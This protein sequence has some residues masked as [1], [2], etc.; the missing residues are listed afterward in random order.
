VFILVSQLLFAAGT[1]KGLNVFG[2][3]EAEK[4]QWS[5]VRPFLLIVAGFLGE[6]QGMTGL[7]MCHLADMHY[8]T[9]YGRNVSSVALPERAER[10]EMNA[11]LIWPPLACAKQQ[12]RFVQCIM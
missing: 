4:L 7:L 12:T 5:L 9:L 3:L 10:S 8:C 11:W 6:Q 2:V 1:V